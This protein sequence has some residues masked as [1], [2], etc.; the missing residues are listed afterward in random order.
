MPYMVAPRRIYYR[1]QEGKR[2]TRTASTKTYV[3]EV[4]DILELNIPL[5]C[6]STILCGDCSDSTVWYEDGLPESD[7][8]ARQLEQRDSRMRANRHLGDISIQRL[9][10]KHQRWDYSLQA[11]FAGSRETLSTFAYRRPKSSLSSRWL[12]P[13]SCPSI[14]SQ[15]PRSW[16]RLR[17]EERRQARSGG[18]EARLVSPFSVLDFEDELERRTVGL[19]IVLYGMFKVN[20]NDWGH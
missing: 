18:P 7:R 12:C 2:K 13:P 10:A 3:E 14:C 4:R 17:V 20:E 19:R 1:S 11:R 16:A 15:D 8:G 6:S 9:R 5:V